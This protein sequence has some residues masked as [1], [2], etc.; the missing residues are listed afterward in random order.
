[1]WV[2]G[3]QESVLLAPTEYVEALVDADVDTFATVLS[4]TTDDLLKARP[5]RSRNAR[6]RGSHLGSAMRSR[7]CWR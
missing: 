1:M 4:V 6:R 5:T 3:V 7:S 2:E